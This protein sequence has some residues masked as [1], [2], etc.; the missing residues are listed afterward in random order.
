MRP[1]FIVIPSPYCHYLL[2]VACIHIALAAAVVLEH[3]FRIQV[4]RDSAV[5]RQ[6]PLPI[7]VSS[8]T[9]QS[10]TNAR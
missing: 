3:L 10:K 4:A 5:H 6:A 2:R 7:F 8:R 1:A 9:L